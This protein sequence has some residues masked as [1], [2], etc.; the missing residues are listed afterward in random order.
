MP[1]PDIQP[2]IVD[3]DGREIIGNDVQGN[4]CIKFPWPSMIRTIYGDHQRCKDVY[5]STYKGKYFTGDGCKEIL[6]AFIE[7]LEELMMLSMFQG[8]E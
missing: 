5:F 2:C 4:L 7:L 1:L 8:T 3:A 6:M